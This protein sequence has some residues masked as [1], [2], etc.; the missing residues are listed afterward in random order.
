MEGLSSLLNHNQVQIRLR[1][2]PIYVDINSE[3][4]AVT[5]LPDSVV[6]TS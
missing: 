2:V 6:F 3:E 1:N 5:G 4:Y